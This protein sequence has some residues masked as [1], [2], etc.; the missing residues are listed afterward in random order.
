MGEGGELFAGSSRK[1]YQ[2]VVIVTHSPLIH[3]LQMVYYS[4]YGYYL[5]SD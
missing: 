4:Y 2:P 5:I 3:R 1:Q